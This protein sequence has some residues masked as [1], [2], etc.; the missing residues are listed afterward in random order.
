MNDEISALKECLTQCV[1]VLKKGG[2]IVIMSY[3]SLEDRIVKNLLKTG[4]VDGIE[5]KDPIYG[6]SEKVF[7]LKSSK[8]IVPN[9]EEIKQN[10]R[11]R[12]AKLR[13]ALKL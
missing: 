11:A 5:E 12:S 4:N 7:K 10:N 13:V 6:T 3:H 9:E 1:D 8:P 2:S